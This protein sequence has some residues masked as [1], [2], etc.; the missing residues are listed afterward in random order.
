MGKSGIVA[1][2]MRAGRSVPTN[3]ITLNG[4]PIPV[5]SLDQPYKHLG[6]WA[7]VMGDFIAEKEQARSD[8]SK[9]LE[10][11]TED[12]VLS[13]REKEVVIRIVVCSVFCYSAGLGDW[14]GTELDTISKM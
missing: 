5:I 6:V 13:R 7:T 3:S 12:C 2:N 1:I 11:L 8:M 10:S 9:K 14:T 4:V